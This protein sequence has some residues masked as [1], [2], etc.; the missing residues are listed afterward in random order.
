MKMDAS[1]KEFLNH[2]NIAVYGASRSV[3]KFG[4]TLAAE[5]K[6]RGYTVRLVH[7]EAQEISGEPCAKNMEE[8]KDEVSAAVIC[9][10][11]KAAAEAIRDAAQ[12]GVQQIWLQQGANGV[13]TGKVSQELGVNPITG[14][15]LLM[16]AEPVAS[17]HSFHRFFAKLF[18]AY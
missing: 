5:L 15:C 11:P 6:Q 3:N 7:P 14:K 1:V 13:E 2:K 18:G 12:A 10:P 9:L 17:Y 8:I 4:N 16:Y